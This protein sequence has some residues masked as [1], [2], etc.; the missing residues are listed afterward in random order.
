MED[1]AIPRPATRHCRLT[2]R[3]FTSGESFY[4]V[5]VEEKKNYVLYDYALDAWTGPPPGTVGYWMAKMSEKKDPTRKKM[6][7]NDIL[8]AVFD[9]LTGDTQQQDKLYI[10]SL[11]MIRRRIFRL[12]DE[13]TSALDASCLAIYCPRRDESYT[14]P[15][16]VPEAVRQ[17]EIQD[18][19][20]QLLMGEPDASTAQVQIDAQALL[21]TDELAIPEITEIDDFS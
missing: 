3:E 16:V 20:A 6:A 9:N 13:N 7:V 2:H 5:L 10:L 8:L 11:L 21:E 19:L 12:D 1:Y 15:A 14:I 4:A 17:A 18:E